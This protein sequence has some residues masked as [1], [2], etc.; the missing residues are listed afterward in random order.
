MP[1]GV[2]GPGHYHYSSARHRD[3]WGVAMRSLESAVGIQRASLALWLHHRTGVGRTAAISR[4]ALSR[5]NRLGVRTA[6]IPHLT[7]VVMVR[8]SSAC[9]EIAEDQ[10]AGKRP[11]QPTHLS[12]WSAL[13]VHSYCSDATMRNWCILGWLSRRCACYFGW[14]YTISA[15]LRK[16]QGKA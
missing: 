15:R 10:G 5:T 3:C 1:A 9:L 7:R 6:T 16:A 4:P 14:S 8:L 13:S 12:K 11:K 2:E